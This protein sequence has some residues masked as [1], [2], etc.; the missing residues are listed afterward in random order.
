M[1]F[2]DLR[3]K[4]ALGFPVGF[5]ETRG[6]PAGP[7]PEPQAQT[8]RGSADQ[9]GADRTLQHLWKVLSITGRVWLEHLE[10]V[11]SG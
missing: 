11:S 7:L 3:S 4:A 1:S 9:T 2:R 8:G 10:C 5:P 6:S